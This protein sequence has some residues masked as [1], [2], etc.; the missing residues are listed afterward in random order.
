[1]KGATVV[2]LPIHFHDPVGAQRNGE[3]ASSELNGLSVGQGPDGAIGMPHGVG[4]LMPRPNPPLNRSVLGFKGTPEQEHAAHGGPSSNARHD[5]KVLTRYLRT[6]RALHEALRGWGWAV[7]AVAVAL[8][9]V[10]WTQS[11]F[12][13]DEFSA[14]LRLQATDSWSAFW[15]KAVLVDAHPAGVQAFLTG[16]VALGD[17]I[18]IAQ[19][20]SAAWWVKWPFLMVS[21]G[22]V[23]ALAVG[24]RRLA[25]REAAWLTLAM[26]G[27]L[28]WAVLQSVIARPYAP[29][30]AA[31]LWAG[32]LL[33][34]PPS[35]WRWVKLG[36]ALAAAGYLHHFAALQ[37]GLLL[38]AAAAWGRR[39]DRP[40]FVK[41]ALLGA[42]LYAPHVPVL[43][44][45]WGHGGLGTFL[46]P[47]TAAFVRTYLSLLLNDSVWLWSLL[48][49]GVGG[50]VLGVRE[51][52]VWRAVGLGGALFA[53]PLGLAYAYSVWREPILMDRTLF[54]AS[55]FLVTAVSVAAMAGW[56]RWTSLPAALWV[57][58][59]GATA[60]VTLFTQRHHHR[61][62]WQSA[63]VGAFS[64]AMEEPKALNLWNGPEHAW[65][66]VGGQ[67]GMDA[68]SIRPVQWHDVQAAAA[69]SATARVGLVR[70]ANFNYLTPDADALLWCHRPLLEQR[71]W[72]NGDYR[73]YG[74]VR[75]LGV[76]PTGCASPGRL[77]SD[78]EFG[79][80]V[81]AGLGE[82]LTASGVEGGPTPCREVFA[83]LALTEP[84][85]EGA[86]LVLSCRWGE[87]GSFYRSVSA[88]QGATGW[89][90]VGVRLADLALTP[91]DASQTECSAY[92]WNPLRHRIETGP[93]VLGA[94][95]GNRF[96]YAWSQAIPGE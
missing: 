37:A 34:A 67:T 60:V 17:A 79:P 15:T 32:A 66:W 54:F 78:G 86:E 43:L 33:L 36:V 93:L 41:A 82:L 84:L 73:L 53:M 68:S 55:P 52:R 7:M 44:H 40:D 90:A 50:A 25:G 46:D 45:Q 65:A 5:R 28:D 72:Y 62:A 87:G 11:S 80:T 38:G 35:R 95:A 21:V 27:G 20:G 76:G 31:V 3:G 96:Q 92:L 58:F 2:Q 10:A 16:W 85:P 69:D 30:L 81:A 23:G 77:R 61:T 83:G 18:G 49:L 89:V 13:H 70:A 75:P 47:P 64:A 71:N 19:A 63:Y 9:V 88:E 51:S 59:V 22:G 48:L 94:A 26:W 4:R 74:A 12:S 6:M 42:A 91:R 56:R 14:L 29:G 39:G 24:V 57:A 8:R 1:M